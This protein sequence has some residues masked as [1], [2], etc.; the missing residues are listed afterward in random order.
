MVLGW[1]STRDSILQILGIV[2]YRYKDGILQ[3]LTGLHFTGCK[4]GILQ[5]VGMAY[6]L[7]LRM[8]HQWY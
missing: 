7:V 3:V 8:V 4:D 5:V 2:Y 6:L 1:Q